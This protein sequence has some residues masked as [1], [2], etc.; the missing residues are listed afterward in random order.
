M[1]DTPNL[2]L[3]YILAAQAQKHVTHNEAI[4]ALD[5]L[6]Q[7]SVESRAL[8]AP[9]AT[10][11]DG[12]RYLVAAAATGD[13]AGNTDKIAAFQDGAWAFFE[14]REG[15]IAWVADEHELIIYSASA[16][17]PY[18]GGSGGEGGGG[19]GGGLSA[20]VANASLANMA[21]GTIK[22]RTSAGSGHPEDLT[23]AQATALLDT[24]G[25]SGESHKKGLVPDPG[26]TAGTSKFLR[27]D[28]SWAEPPA[29][30]G[31]GDAGDITELDDLDHLGI[32]TTADSTNVL[33]LKGPASLFDNAGNGHQQKINK[34]ADT[35]TASVLYQT[36]YSGRAEMGLTGDD[37]F[38]FKVSPNGATWYDALKIDRNSGKIS[39]PAMGGP[40]EILTAN[41]TY[42]VRTDG[43]DS[44]AGLANT[45]GGAFL[46]IQKA[47]DTVAALDL[48]IYN[49]T[50]Q[51]A[52]GTYT[53]QV[54]RKGPWV[55]S[56]V[57]TLQGNTATP[58][59]CIISATSGHAIS[60]LNGASLTIDGFELRTTTS[61]N[62]IDCEY[63]GNVT[64]G[65][66]MRFGTS[67]GRH[68]DARTGATIQASSY[69][70][71]GSAY[72][73]LSGQEGGYMRVLNGTITVSG[74]PT[75]S[76]FAEASSCGVITVYTVTISGSAN[77]KRY[78]AKLGSVINTFGGGANF[79]PGSTAGTTATGAQ[80]A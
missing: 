75:F 39:Y 58:G 24:F 62:C 55:G 50:I 63:G 16:W 17:A 79:F 76:Q 49:V 1:N 19:E 40:R 28:G 21:T 35:D 27:E 3:P 10:P 33:A 13:W 6:V 11:A 47:L 38:H 66:H 5:C 14:P 68:M 30:D 20:P 78:D 44:N 59:N 12:S 57:V 74:S 29:G 4:R 70:V 43:S 72:T 80:Y 56:G 52:D 15:W 18:G 65:A 60:V 23:G 25:A 64:V 73:H 37:D 31:G 8:T 71:V 34:H 54:S 22:G 7:L 26:D 42:Y 46:T 53:D 41:R 77:G 9:P 51:V 45:S 69:S 36:N 48:S 67:A 2:A 32:A 61:G